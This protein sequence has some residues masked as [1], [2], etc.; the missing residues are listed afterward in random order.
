MDMIHEPGEA[1]KNELC[2]LCFCDRK[3]DYWGRVVLRSK[4]FGLR[5]RNILVFLNDGRLISRYS[6]E[7]TNPMQT[8]IARRR[9]HPRAR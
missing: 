4:R 8:R 9:D 6:S 5:T 1:E 3:P 7:R 2:L